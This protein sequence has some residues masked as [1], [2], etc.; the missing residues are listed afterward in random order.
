MN[1]QLFCVQP[2]SL[3][4]ERGEQPLSRGSS[5]LKSLALFWFAFAKRSSAMKAPVGLLSDR[6]VSRQ[7]DGGVCPDK[8]RFWRQKR[9]YPA[10]MML[11]KAIAPSL[12][13]NTLPGRVSIS[14]KTKE[15]MHMFRATAPSLFAL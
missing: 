1:L 7:R 11:A 2:T 6:A 10:E 3:G 13:D 4:S 8:L 12:R 14:T 5:A 9:T 15:L